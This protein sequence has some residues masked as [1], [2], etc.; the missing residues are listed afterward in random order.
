MSVDEDGSLIVCVLNLKGLRKAGQEKGNGSSRDSPSSRA[1]SGFSNDLN[2][3]C[4]TQTVHG[5]H[6]AKIPLPPFWDED[7]N[8]S[9]TIGAQGAKLLKLA[10]IEPLS[11]GRESVLGTATVDIEKLCLKPAD[12]RTVTVPL[13]P[14]GEIKLT[15][16]YVGAKPLF[17]LDLVIVITEPIS[18]G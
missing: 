3:S 15:F 2:L 11:F 4:K 18:Y 14:R 7:D 9:F 17:A 8:P 13:S 5:L 16:S 1:R 10:V 12:P 6:R